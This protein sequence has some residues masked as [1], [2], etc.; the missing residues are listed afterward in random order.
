MKHKSMAEMNRE[1]ALRKAKEQADDDENPS[2]YYKFLNLFYKNKKEQD[3]KQK[4]NSSTK[5]DD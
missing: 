3:D 5:T 1:R 4:T 2:A